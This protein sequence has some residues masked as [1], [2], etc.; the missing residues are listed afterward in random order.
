MDPWWLSGQFLRFVTMV[1]KNQRT[2]FDIL[3][4]ILKK[5]RTGFDILTMV[6]R[7]FF[8]KIK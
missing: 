6:L 8:K 3:T 5:P 1:L 7:F 2:G 4:M